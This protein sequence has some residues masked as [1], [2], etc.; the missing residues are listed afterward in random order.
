[1]ATKSIK[2][3]NTTTNVDIFNATINSSA[4]LRGAVEAVT[5]P[6]GLGSAWNVIE[7][8][9][10]LKNEFVS[11]LMNR[12]GK[13]LITSKSYTNPLASLKKGLL[14]F[15]E[16]VEDIYINL[17]EVERFDPESAE[18]TLYARTIPDVKTSLYRKNYDVVYPTTI[19]LRELSKAFMTDTG[20]YDFVTGVVNSLI[21][22][23]N[24]DEY[25]VTKYML[26]KRVANGLMGKYVGVS[27]S[28]TDEQNAKG[29]V[30]AIKKVGN[31]LTFMN[32]DNNLMGVYNF[33]LKENQYVFLTA[34]TLAEVDVDVLAS[35][36][37]MDKVSFMGHVVMVDDFTTLDNDRL[38][39]LLGDDEGL[40]EDEIEL[41]SEV[42]A[43]ICDENFFQ[44]YD[45]YMDTSVDVF[46]AKGLYTNYFL[47]VSRIFAMSP[48]SQSV[49]FVSDSAITVSG[50]VSATP[51]S[52]SLTI[53]KG[54]TFKITPTV[55]ITSGYGMTGAVCEAVSD[56]IIVKPDGTITVKADATNGTK[57]VKIVPVQPEITPIEYT[58]TVG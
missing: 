21:T 11:T 14:Q 34:D 15:G 30:K 46:N 45:A 26:C 16:L 35:A 39:K 23:S 53:G 25:A 13:V 38:H 12:I 8:N 51:T 3:I 47:H 2:K 6:E 50:T 36:F 54:L 18:T 28:G 49:A 56:D 24:V 41:L 57:K 9:I 31:K 52:G 1:M 37:N 58:F 42:R 5:T 10:E 43:V 48:F 4:K 40:T 55:S 32:N 22:A 29:L 44:I 19:Q 7:N 33:T 17:A 20:L 27:T